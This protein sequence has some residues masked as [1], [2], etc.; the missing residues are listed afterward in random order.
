[1]TDHR[2]HCRCGAV[3]AH[4]DGEPEHSVF[5]HCDDCRRTSG[6]PLI[7]A[8]GVNRNAVTWEAVADLSEYVNGTCTRLFCRVCGSSI[9]QQHES[10][11]D[12]TF[13]NTTFM[14]DPEKFPPTFHSFGGRQLSW[15]ELSDQLPRYEKTKVIETD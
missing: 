9:A 14:D 11:P 4:I 1:M 3:V 12:M 5:Y 7:A 6:A 10:A 2:G 13:F 8:I 15:L